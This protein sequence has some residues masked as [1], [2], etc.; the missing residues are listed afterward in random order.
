[1]SKVYVEIKVLDHLD[2]VRD[3]SCQRTF[4]KHPSLIVF[5]EYQRIFGESDQVYHVR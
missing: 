5:A 3:Y 1:V 2:H 4:K